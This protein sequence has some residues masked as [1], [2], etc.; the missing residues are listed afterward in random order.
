MRNC[1]NFD[2]IIKE[3]KNIKLQEVYPNERQKELV[4]RTE[5]RRSERRT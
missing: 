2:I 3:R 5:P 1:L 4:I